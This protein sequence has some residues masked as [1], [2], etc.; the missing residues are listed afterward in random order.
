MLFLCALLP[1]AA[2]TQEPPKNVHVVRASGEA[3]VTAKP[4]RAEI[5]I[6][7]VTQ[8][9][10]AQAAAAQNA[11]DTT[12]VLDSL[13]R[14]LSSGG[15][16]K[17]TGYSIG[18]DYQYSK[19]GA[20][21]KVSGYHAANGVRVTVDE[22]PLIGKVIDAA[23]QSGATTVGGLSYTL[24]ND[25]AVRAQALAEAA[26][27]AR[28]AAEAI[29]KALDLHVTGILEAASTDTVPQPPSPL[30]FGALQQT[31]EAGTPIEATTIEIHASVTVTLEVR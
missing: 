21:R 11:T 9:P 8:A 12:Q 20:P 2:L 29:A 26:A 3:T 13:K 4:D 7:V 15:Q 17:T 24:R 19:N 25:D 22:L 23:S 31:V 5:S 16:V 6:S 10:T 27:K 28:S 1:A 30:R 14:V 18:P